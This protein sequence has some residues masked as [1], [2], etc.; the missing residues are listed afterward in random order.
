MEYQLEH[1]GLHAMATE[2][3]KE[4]AEKLAEV[5]QLEVREG[6][7]SYFAGQFFECMKAPYLGKYGHIAMRTS[8][9]QAAKEELES[10]GLHFREDTAQYD[11]QGR[12]KNI[13]LQEEWGGFAFHIMEKQS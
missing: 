7:K 2:D 4:L 11:A 6:Q 9:L 5:F 12:L 10:K 1:V 8:D 13:Y 3:A